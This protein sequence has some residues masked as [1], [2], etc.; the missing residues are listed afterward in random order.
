MLNSHFTLEPRNFPVPYD[1]SYLDWLTL[2][3]CDEVRVSGFR[4]LDFEVISYAAI[5]FLVDGKIFQVLLE[6][7]FREF[8]KP[9]FVNFFLRCLNTVL[10]DTTFLSLCLCPSLNII[11][12]KE[13]FLLICFA[14]QEGW[15]LTFSFYGQL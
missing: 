6:L 2:R 4:P 11:F 12:E 14:F 9:I 5:V 7:D 13:G 10:A 3:N 8:N 1:Y 15:G